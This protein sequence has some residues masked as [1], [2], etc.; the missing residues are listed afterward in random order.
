MKS[1]FENRIT[2]LQKNGLQRVFMWHL[3]S[4]ILTFSALTLLAWQQEGH[5]ACK[6]MSDD[7]L[8]GYLSGVRCRFAYGP[9]DAAVVH[10]LSLQ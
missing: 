7:V 3:F 4:I 8:D 1:P 10:H 2:G 5:P 9:P 6:K